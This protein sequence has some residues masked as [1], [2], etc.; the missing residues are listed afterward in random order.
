MPDDRNS[1]KNGSKPQMPPRPDHDP[2]MLVTFRKEER[3]REEIK[4]KTS[5]SISKSDRPSKKD[6]KLK[7]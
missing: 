3:P 1:S 4:P 5:V 6:K 2:E 7:K